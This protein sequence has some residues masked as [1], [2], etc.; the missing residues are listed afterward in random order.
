MSSNLRYI[1]QAKTRS[2]EPTW[3]N[4]IYECKGIGFKSY[5]QQKKDTKYESSESRWYKPHTDRPTIYIS[6]DEKNFSVPTNLSYVALAIEDSISMLELEE[7][8]DGANGK[9]I[10]YKTWS[11]AS[12]FLL[13]YSKYILDKFGSII[14][15][16]EI[17]ASG[18]GSIDLVWKTQNARLLVNFKPSGNQVLASCY[19]DLYDNKQP[20]KSLIID[21]LV[22]EHLAFWMKNLA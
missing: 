1:T 9:K 19:G 3:K 11:N 17:N 4:N 6:I 20:I 2:E 16:P 21:E 8:W 14:K 15:S 22:I 7:D 10:E 12:T 5:E 18:N 13:S